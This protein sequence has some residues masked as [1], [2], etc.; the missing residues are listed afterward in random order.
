M[1]LVHGGTH[2]PNW[3]PTC[4][5]LAVSR[6]CVCSKA[7]ERAGEGRESSAPAT[8]RV[9]EVS[10]ALARRRPLRADSAAG[11]SPGVQAGWGRR[12]RGQLSSG[13]QGAAGWL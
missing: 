7:F 5:T 10:A 8:V 2:T 12:P 6:G 4:V 3:T 11:R 13:R 1:P 9:S